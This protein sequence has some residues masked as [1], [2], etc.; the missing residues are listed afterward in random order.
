MSPWLAVCR[1]IWQQIK[2]KV[3]HVSYCVGA[4]VIAIPFKLPSV[5]TFL[6]QC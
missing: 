6:V 2:D 1:V 4:I 3:R 5:A